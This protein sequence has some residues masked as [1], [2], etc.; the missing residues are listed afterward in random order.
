VEPTVAGA[1]RPLRAAVE[2]L[3]G[4]SAHADRTEL[5]RWL[6]AVR[7]RSPALGPVFLVHGEPRAQDALAAPLVAD[8]NHVRCPALGARVTL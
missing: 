6:A 5:M 8:G 1:A 7:E 4:Y 2:V 3:N